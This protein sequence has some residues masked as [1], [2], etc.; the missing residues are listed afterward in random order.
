MTTKATHL[1]TLLGEQHHLWAAAAKAAECSPDLLRSATR[2]PELLSGLQWALLESRL[3]EK[4]GWLGTGA[5]WSPS[6]ADTLIRNTRGRLPSPVELQNM[7]RAN[8]RRL[9]DTARPATSLSRLLN[10]SATML[11]DLMNPNADRTFG[12]KRARGLEEALGLPDGWL[13]REGD[14]VPREL[15]VRLEQYRVDA[16]ARGAG[17]RLRPHL[18]EGLAGLQPTPVVPGLLAIGGLLP[19]HQAVLAKYHD[20]ALGG[21]LDEGFALEL[22]GT[23]LKREQVA[24][25]AAPPTSSPAA[26][27]QA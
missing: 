6:H 21:Q 19:L 13:D 4:P 18:P 1:A 22:M 8:L 25:G 5:A 27:S 24:V 20:L 17:A 23:L 3:G 26:A 10:T 15:R 16:Q 7:R 9:A 2:R 12:P 11:A 14:E